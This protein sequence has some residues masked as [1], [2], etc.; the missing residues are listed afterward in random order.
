MTRDPAVVLW[1]G[2]K[3]SALA[4]QLAAR[5]LD[6]RGLLTTVT[7]GYERISMHGVRV[8]L[9]ERQAAA[10]GYPLEV[11]RIPACC[12]NSDYEERM[13]AALDRQRR[14]GVRRVVCGD[15]FLED[16]R[17]YREDRLFGAGLEGVY[18]LWGWP[19][20]ALAREVIAQGYRAVLCCVDTRVLGLEYAGRLYDEQ[21]LADLPAGV[22]P[23]GE[24]GEMHTFVFDGPTFRHG[25]PFRVGERVLRDE[26]FGYVELLPEDPGGADPAAPGP[27]R[28]HGLPGMPSPARRAV[29]P[30]GRVSGSGRCR[31]SCRGPARA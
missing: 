11:V 27:A 18:P 17:R 21:L 30:P 7:E 16:V 8:A 10:L 12:A 23:A 4:L 26:R 24:R 15:L 1:S 2:G 14:A 29:A 20:P 6:V 13:G 31:W 28:E 9:L 3:D 25:V 22:D 5:E 19:T